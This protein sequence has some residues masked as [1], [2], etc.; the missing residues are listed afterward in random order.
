M[1]Y[2]IVENLWEEKNMTLQELLMSLVGQTITA[3]HIGQI[4]ASVN[5]LIE[6]KKQEVEKTLGEE[7]TKLEGELAELKKAKEALD[8]TIQQASEEKIFAQFKLQDKQIEIARKL[9][10]KD[11]WAAADDK[12]KIALIKALPEETGGLFTLPKLE[13]AGGV[14]IPPK[15]FGTKENKVKEETLPK[16]EY[17]SEEEPSQ[18]DNAL[19]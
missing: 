8:A 9:I 5:Q 12:G 16:D 6:V 18:F 13:G 17:L 7:K 3:T 19:I 15:K 1:T 10:D 14:Q 4:N 2:S 11:K